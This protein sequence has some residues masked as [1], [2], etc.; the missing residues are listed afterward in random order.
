MMRPFKL[1]VPHFLQRFIAFFILCCGLSISISSH[2]QKSIESWYNEK[3]ERTGSLNAR[4]YSLLSRTDSGWLRKDI[5]VSTRQWQMIG[6][7]EDQGETIKNGVFQWFYPDGKL[8]ST[9]NYSQNK[10]TGLFLEFYSDGSLKDSSYYVAGNLQG[11]SAGWHRNGQSS[12]VFTVDELGKGVYTNWFSDGQPSSAGRYIDYNKK[13][14]RWQY[15][16]KNGKVSAIKLYDSGIVK[17]NQFFTEEGSPITDSPEADRNAEF[18]GGDLAW[19]KYISSNLYFPAHLDIKHGSLVA[20]VVSFNINEEGKIENIEVDL[21]VHP[22]MDK[23]AVDAIKRSPL[24]KPA[25]SQNRRVSSNFIQ[26]VSF[27]TLSYY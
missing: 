10:R 2:A 12:Y 17:A 7:F 8:K 3:W 20:L 13:H 27:Y 4:Y 6:L 25:I 21:P 15:F 18:P 26:T 5:Y 14:G 1:L 9:G 11:V 19:R 23:I 16:H 22:Q 24:W